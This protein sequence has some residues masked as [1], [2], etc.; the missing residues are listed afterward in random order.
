MY[1]VVDLPPIV[2]GNHREDARR[3]R[4]GGSQRDR[5]SGKANQVLILYSTQEKKVIRALIV[6]TISDHECFLFIPFNNCRVITLHY[7]YYVQQIIE[8]IATVQGRQCSV[9]IGSVLADV[10]IVAATVNP[11]VQFY[12]ERADRGPSMHLQSGPASC[13]A[14]VEGSGKV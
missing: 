11:T 3:E 14:T 8:R 6:L 4:G 9:S 7:C 10:Y 5:D 1:L 13:L 2:D 12:A